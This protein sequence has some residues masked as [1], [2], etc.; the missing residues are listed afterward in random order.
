MK[1]CD[2][3]ETWCDKDFSLLCGKA[4]DF[5][6]Y[7]VPFIGCVRESLLRN[8]F[9]HVE[10]SALLLFDLM[11]S[12]TAESETHEVCGSRFKHLFLS[13]LEKA[14]SKAYQP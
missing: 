13:L 14:G 11:K 7:S 6:D 4:E 9:V 5:T 12:I 10:C 1:C 2:T 3:G 8:P